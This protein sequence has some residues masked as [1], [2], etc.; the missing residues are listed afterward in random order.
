MPLIEGIGDEVILVFAFLVIVIVL[1]GAWMS[2]HI[3]EIPLLSLIILEHNQ[4]RRQET[5][6]TPQSQQ[7]EEQVPT[8]IESESEQLA[9]SNE[10]GEESFETETGSSSIENSSD[11]LAQSTPHV[12]DIISTSDPLENIECETDTESDDSG[13]NLSDG[14]LRR[15]RIAFLTQSTGIDDSK[16][17]TNAENNTNQG[18]KKLQNDESQLTENTSNSNLNSGENIQQVN[19]DSSQTE[20]VQNEDQVPESE[21]TATGNAGKIQIR[22]KYMNDTQKSV[23]ANPRET[24]GQF[25][26]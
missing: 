12:Q 19:N 4:R 11:F 23:V 14:E 20:S 25:R 21:V 13:S 22:I 8:S 7:Q 9:P 24:I 1:V 16:D 3:R 26:R 17:V 15:R 2:T 6:N 18:D 5:Q 10:Q